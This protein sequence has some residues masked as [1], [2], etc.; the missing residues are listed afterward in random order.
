MNR[1]RKETKKTEDLVY[2]EEWASEVVQ[3]VDQAAGKVQV[4]PVV[5]ALALVVRRTRC[6]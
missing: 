1:Q 3:A 6:K 2:L 5:Q 4:V